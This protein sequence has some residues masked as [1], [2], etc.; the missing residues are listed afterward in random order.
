MENRL[1][2]GDVNPYLAL[3]AMLAGGLYGIEHG[4]ELEPETSGN[5]Y[6]SGA[7][8]VPTTMREARDALAA[9]H[10]AREVFGEDVVTHYL[11]YADVELAAFES[12]VTDWEL[13]R[14]F[15]RL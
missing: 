10:I 12:A 6:E 11:N 4:L 14:G 9:S 3:A 5:A 15:E 8:T 1:P 2:G 7:P 13:R